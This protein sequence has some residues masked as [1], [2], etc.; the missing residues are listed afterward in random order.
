MRTFPKRDMNAKYSEVV[1]AELKSKR[2]NW[3]NIWDEVGHFV[4]PTKADFI[5]ERSK[6]D[7]RDEDIYDSTAVTANQ[8]LASGLHGA[9]TAPS[10]RWFHIRF[11]EE[12][13]N[14]DDAA[15]CSPSWIPIRTPVAA[16]SKILTIKRSPSSGTP[17]IRNSNP[18][19]PIAASA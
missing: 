18:G 15:I 1:F 9:L 17:A 7:K 6:G 14:N 19:M 3:N 11:R 8:T 10:G 13:L 12:G 4:L 16:S 2:E 5:T